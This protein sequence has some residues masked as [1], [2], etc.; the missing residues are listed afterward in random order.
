MLSLLSAG[1][2][3]EISPQLGADHQDPKNNQHRPSPRATGAHHCRR[4]GKDHQVWKNQYCLGTTYSDV[5]VF[6][7]WH[8]LPSWKETFLQ[9]FVPV[10]GLPHFWRGYLQFKTNQTSCFSDLPY[11]CFETLQTVNFVTFIAQAW[12][13]VIGFVPELPGEKPPPT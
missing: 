6:H 2:W 9:K 7:I 3:R 11:Y 12:L 10:A 8:E 13:P 5:S 1:R 4:I